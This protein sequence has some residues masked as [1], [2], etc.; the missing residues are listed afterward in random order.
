MVFSSVEFLFWF[1]PV[2]LAA[3]T[4]AP[5]RARNA[6]L[7]AASLVFYAWGVGGLVLAFAAGIVLNHRLG[8]AAR[9]GRRWPLR[10]AV[11]VDLG[12]LLVAKYGQWLVG[13]AH[14]PQLL[15]NA[16]V[17]HRWALPLG[18][19]F[20]TFQTLSYHLDL[21]RGLVAA[22][23]SLVDFGLFVALFPHQVAGPILRYHLIEPALRDRDVTVEGFAAGVVRF[24]QG[25]VKKV[26]VADAIAPV[27]NAVF[28]SPPAHVGLVAGWLGVLSFALQLFF[29]FSGYSDMAI[30]LGLM[31]GFVI[32]E[33][34]DHPYTSSSMA[35]FWRR[36]HIS[37]GAWFR[38][39]VYLP[40]GG[41]RSHRVRNVLVVF[42][43]IG[44]WHGAA[45]TFLVFGLYHGTLVLLDRAPT[46]TDGP[47]ARR[48]VRRARTAGLVMVGWVLFRA[49]SLGRAFG[50]YRAMVGAGAGLLGHP[51]DLRKVIDPKVVVLTALAATAFLI[52]SRW[53]EARVLATG[54]T[55]AATAARF[56]LVGVGLPYAALLVAAT[57]FHP[58][59]Y[60]RF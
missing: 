29:D 46:P 49:P 41:G 1:L 15:G 30:G 16:P 3:H 27:A 7:L 32:P 48:L 37:L 45:A 4:L 57:N 18:L 35:E 54:R 56:A 9:P 12:V 22:Q 40:L 50:L 13:L 34:F 39:Y 10:T 36:W 5:R 11:V 33:N 19:S 6:V 23:R 28:A 60:Y 43:L 58:F 59:L 2:T 25:L 44:L 24:S 26:V 21:D 17:H 51:D 14:L 31:F 53:M 38:D 55:S 42:V 20:F 47:V 8:L 52:P